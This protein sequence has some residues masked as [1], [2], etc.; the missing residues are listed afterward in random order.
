MKLKYKFEIEELAGSFCAT[1]QHKCEFVGMIRM[2]STAKDVFD[3]LREDISIE[4]I[5]KTLLNK[6]N[7][8]TEILTEEVKKTIKVFNDYGIIDECEK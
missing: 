3:L 7:V 6:Y 5:I 2:N 8:D 1:P 4:E